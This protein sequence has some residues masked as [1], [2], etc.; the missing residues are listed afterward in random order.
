MS[1]IP[2]LHSQPQ[3]PPDGQPD[4][5]PT[6]PPGRPRHG[7]ERPFKIV[8]L[9]GLAALVALIAYVVVD[10]ETAHSPSPSSQPPSL[11][12][13]VTAPHFSLPRLGGGAPVSLATSDGRPVV[14]NFFASWC[15][16]CRQEL[17]AVATVAAAHAAQVAVIGVDTS[18]PD[19]STAQRLLSAAG[20]T[21]PVGTD[22][23][24]RVA[25]SYRIVGIPVTY[26][27]LHG[28]VMGVAFGAQTVRSLDT[29][30]TRLTAARAAS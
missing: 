24:G 5:G 9:V 22:R 19:P 27:V 30:V 18:D 21:Y 1:A 13:G 28:R 14:V 4:P 6:A 26:F 29:W 16:D 12:A 15:S 17:R 8:S 20:A 25:E 23:S 2:E 3:H 7:S 10:T 11:A